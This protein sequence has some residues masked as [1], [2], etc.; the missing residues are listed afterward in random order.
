MQRA[1]VLSSYRASRH[2][3]APSLGQ[4]A[5]LSFIVIGRSQRSEVR[6]QNFGL[7]ISDCGKL[8]DFN[9]LNDLNG[10]D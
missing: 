4:D 7:R 10:F 8:Y 3:A 1:A 9:G 2:M 5:L 6:G